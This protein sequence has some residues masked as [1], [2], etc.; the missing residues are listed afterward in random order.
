MLEMIDKTQRRRDTE[1]FPLFF[2][3][4]ETVHPLCNADVLSISIC[5]ALKI[6]YYRKGDYKSPPQIRRIT[7]PP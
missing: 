7:N 3:K 5:D 6:P 2:E 4:A 1:P